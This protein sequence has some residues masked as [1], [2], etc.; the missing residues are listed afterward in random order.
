MLKRNTTA[1]LLVSWLL[2][3]LAR[4]A[5]VEASPAFS[6]DLVSTRSG[7]QPDGR[8][9]HVY[10]SNRK[11][12]IE[13]PEI[14]DGFFIVDGDGRAA[15]FVRP[16]QQVFMA[17]KQSSPLTQLLVPV[18]P[19]DP[20]RQWQVMEDV[21]GI[22]DPSGTWHCDLL[23]R[24]IV[25]GGETMKYLVTSRQQQRS[26]RWI[27]RRRQFP[28]RIAAEDGKG[29][30]LENL[31]DAPQAPSLFTIP[32]DYQQFDPLQLIERIKQSDVWVESPR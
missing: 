1:V 22:T 8:P 31:V 13:S 4:L 20:C 17:A 23:T 9:G 24:E 12:R 2:P 10:I 3:G 25:A 18:D 29:V 32:A 16:R 30:A 26:Y 15:W 14:H 5:A 28:V 19:D 6:A 11:V 27:D 21:A 7:H